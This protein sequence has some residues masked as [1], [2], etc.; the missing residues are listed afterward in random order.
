MKK[1]L[2]FL[3]A[4][5]I[6]LSSLSQTITSANI[7]V[8]GDTIY[9]AED[10]APSI[11]I[12]TTGTGNV[13]DFS[14]LLTNNR[15]TTIFFDPNIISCSANTF[16]N[17][18]HSFKQDTNTAFLTVSPTSIE[19]VGISNGTICVASQD[20][21]TTITFPSS[22][23]TTYLDT[24][25]TTTTVSGSSLGQLPGVDSVKVISVSYIES[26]FNAS[27]TLT[28][29]YGIFTSIRQ[30]LERKTTTELYI[31]GLITGGI[32]TLF[33]T[34]TDTAYSH[35]YWSN[36]ANAKFPLV[37]YDVTATGV[38]TGSVIFTTGFSSN[39]NTSIKENEIKTISVYPNPA[40]DQLTIDNHEAINNLTVTDLRG[41]VI[42]SSNQ[43]TS[44][45]IDIN[46]LSKGMYV[47]T[48]STDSYTGTARFIKQ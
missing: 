13:W 30:D 10:V 19:L 5:S 38:L 48:I 40:K 6:G 27:G 26:D 9:Q 4:I 22:F 47:L 36:A 46:F 3:G 39:V 23:G 31:K 37:S 44:N 43:I 17:P 29:A 1:T 21:E 20:S 2:L 18:T 11:N 16:N 24:A 8:L 33:S 28:T 45:T 42:Y 25:R 7:A 35:Q 14:S 12:G 34:E 32:F 15:D 41:K